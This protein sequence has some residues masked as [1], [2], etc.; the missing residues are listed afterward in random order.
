MSGRVPKVQGRC[1]A[2]NRTD[3]FLGESGFVTCGA[4]EC[5]QSSL[6]SDLLDLGKRLHTLARSGQA[7]ANLQERR[8]DL[9][10]ALGGI[11]PLDATPVGTLLANLT[12][13]AEVEFP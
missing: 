1:P 5:R 11:D 2:C 12:D 9:T 6:A 7:V 13:G 8:Q 3:L 10:I 4:I